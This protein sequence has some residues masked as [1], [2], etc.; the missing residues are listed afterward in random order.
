MNV[1]SD[2]THFGVYSQIK[3]VEFF[4]E[5]D[6]C[7]FELSQDSLRWVR[8]LRKPSGLHII[9]DFQNEI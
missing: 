5:V 4:K 2:V 9:E 3:V 1:P 7:W 6:G 8:L